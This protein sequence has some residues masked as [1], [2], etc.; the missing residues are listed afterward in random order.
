[1]NNRISIKKLEDKIVNGRRQKGVA[2][3]FYNCWAEILDLYGQELYEAM[4][5]KLENTVIFKVRYCKK[6]EELRDKENF[7]VEWQGRQY[8]I[9]Y[10]DFLGYKKDFIKLKCK[11]VL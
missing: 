2:I 5:M 1:M 8:E 3:D 7:I 4:A 11:E 10:P 9:Y 6:L